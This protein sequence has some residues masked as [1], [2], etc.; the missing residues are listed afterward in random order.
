MSRGHL[1]RWWHQHQRAF[2]A[3]SSDVREFLSLALTGILVTGHSATSPHGCHICL[4]AGDSPTGSERELL[5]ELRALPQTVPFLYRKRHREPLFKCKVTR[6]PQYRTALAWGGWS[7][8][9]RTL[10]T[11][12]SLTYP[13]PQ[14]PQRHNS[15]PRGSRNRIRKQFLDLHCSF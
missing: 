12:L 1:W 6:P 5:W 9:S 11:S 3:P 13:H 7:R 14:P 8:G 2:G 15:K 4:V 10:W